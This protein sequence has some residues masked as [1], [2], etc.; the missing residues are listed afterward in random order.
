MPPKHKSRGGFRRS[1]AGGNLAS[2][3]PA[4][5]SHNSVELQDASECCEESSDGIDGDI[6]ANRSLDGDGSAAQDACLPAA[7]PLDDRESDRAA[8]EIR[9]LSLKYRDESLFFI[10]ILGPDVADTAIADRV[11]QRCRRCSA[12]PPAKAL[13]R[14]DVVPWLKIL[15]CARSRA[16][17][18]ALLKEF[19][20][21]LAFT[22]VYLMSLNMQIDAFG[23]FQVSGAM[24]GVLADAQALNSRGEM[25]GFFDIK[26][27]S[28][29]YEWVDKVLVTGYYGSTEQDYRGRAFADSLRHMLN[30]Q[31]RLC[32][33]I[34]VLQQRSSGVPCHTSAAGD[35]LHD[36]CTSDDDWSYAPDTRPYG[37]CHPGFFTT[38]TQDKFGTGS[39]FSRSLKYNISSLLESS[40]MVQLGPDE[41]A[42]KAQIRALQEGGWLDARTRRVQVF[43]QVWNL[44]TDVLQSHEMTVVFFAGGITRVFFT[45]RHTKSEF[46]NFQKPEQFQR[47]I[48]E[49]IALAFL[50]YFW[51]V[52]LQEIYLSW[53]GQFLRIH[54]NS[55]WNIVDLL[56]CIFMT[57]AAVSWGLC[58]INFPRNHFLPLLDADDGVAS[59]HGL[60]LLDF[61]SIYDLYVQLSG[62][63]VFFNLL[64]VLKT[65]RF[66]LKTS[67]VVNTISN[68]AT[69]LFGFLVGFSVIFFGFVYI[70]YVEF[71]LFFMDWH[72]IAFAAG[73]ASN[74]IFQALPISDID[75]L[76]LFANFFF[77][78]QFSFIMVINFISL[79]LVVAIII[80]G[81]ML[82]VE[83]KKMRIYSS[84]RMCDQFVAAFIALICTPFASFPTQAMWPWSRRICERV[85]FLHERISGIFGRRF[86]IHYSAPHFFLSLC[87][88][89]AIP[90]RNNVTFG[91][92]LDEMEK[93]VGTSGD[94]VLCREAVSDVLLHFMEHMRNL[95][96]HDARPPLQSLINNQK[97]VARVQNATADTLASNSSKFKVQLRDEAVLMLRSHAR[98]LQRH[99][100]S[101][102]SVSVECDCL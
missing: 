25:K 49:A 13:Q 101:L 50:A 58:L 83:R 72:T 42:A 68:M 29:W 92:I 67:A 82:S 34:I 87:E 52:E 84:Q 33:S 28:D 47:A 32:G 17:S 1:V 66:H 79:N 8:N 69:P 20:V 88:R 97:L 37:S 11:Q 53:K 64:K 70:A 102:H 75:R 18:M 7:A 15:H 61:H 89:L 57:A 90:E 98:T 44:N 30:W 81:Y 16:A 9:D 10:D 4:H 14:E 40:F 19:F 62:A 65:F 46:Y 5:N 23:S 93:I 91:I 63:V 59:F 3:S 43:V 22:C 38:C 100:D 94:S 27:Q 99:S 48:L 60:A 95:R 24:R 26:S 85:Q 35:V 12:S 51:V 86:Q 56:H 45:E 71:G 21:T 54:F 77:Y 74:A 55:G 80:E 78:W 36:A 6:Q 31:N 2:G 39:N 96:N 76:P 41:S 73:S